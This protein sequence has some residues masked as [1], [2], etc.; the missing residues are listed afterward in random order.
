MASLSSV[1]CESKH[2]GPQGISAMYD[3]DTWKMYTTSNS[4]IVFGMLSP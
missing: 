4:M 2:S 1:V 3:E